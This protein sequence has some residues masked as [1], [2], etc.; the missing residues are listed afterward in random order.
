MPTSS[1]EERLCSLGCL[2]AIANE[3]TRSIV[4][5]VVLM[6][7]NACGVEAFIGCGR[8]RYPK[9]SLNVVAGDRDDNSLSAQ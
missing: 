4:V 2:W 8:C 1:P 5:H 7:V 9:A 6:I 3:I